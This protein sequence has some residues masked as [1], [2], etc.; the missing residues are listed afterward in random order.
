MPRFNSVKRTILLTILIAKLIGGSLSLAAQESTPIAAGDTMTGTLNEDTSSF[1]YDL[2][3]SATPLLL[4]ATSEDFTPT[5]GLAYASGT[6]GSISVSFDGDVG[7]PLFIAPL[8][9]GQD[10]QV[11]VTSNRFPVS[12]DFTLTAVAVETTP[13]NAGETTEGTI[14]L[15]GTPQYFSFDARLGQLV[16]A[17]VQGG[18]FDTRLQLFAPGSIR[19]VAADNDGGAGYDPEIYQAVITRTGTS[20]LEVAPAFAG[21]SGSFT[22]S[23]TLADPPVLEENVPTTI[24][25]GG[26]RGTGALMFPFA[27]GGKFEVTIASLSGDTEGA[28]IAIYQD[29]IRL[30]WEDRFDPENA[31]AVFQMDTRSDNP[32]YIIITADTTFDQANEGQFEVNLRRL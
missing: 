11:Q 14:S 17:T 16:F 4:T 25:L 27:A 28:T 10:A 18:G 3:P 7:N 32:V 5:L 31:P 19:S 8:P 2:L 15:D 13:I 26:S 12:G 24:R 29:D 6:V 9:E 30:I 20:Y 1:N 23:L 21:E 22:L